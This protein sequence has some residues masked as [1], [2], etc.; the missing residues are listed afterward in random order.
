MDAAIAGDDPDNGDTV[1][2]AYARATGFG[3]DDGT[4]AGLSI[5]VAGDTFDSNDSATGAHGSIQARIRHTDIA[6]ARLDIHFAIGF[7]DLDLT[8]AR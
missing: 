8:S 1:L 6:S 4:A 7:L 3:V 5:E 2:V